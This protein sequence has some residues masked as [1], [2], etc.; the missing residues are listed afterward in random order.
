MAGPLDGVRIIDVSEVISGP[1]A[2]MML[3]EQGADVIKVEPPRYG[4]QSRQL[5]NYR[6]GMAALYVNCN[7]GERSIGMNLKTK[8]G[9]ELFYDLVRSADVFVQN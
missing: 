4:E 6:N 9:L 5:S 8:E 3:A 1:L 2:V 7:H